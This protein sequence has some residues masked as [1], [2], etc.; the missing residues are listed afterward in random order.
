MIKKRYGHYFDYLI[1]IIKHSRHPKLC[2]YC[3]KINCHELIFLL[4]LADSAVSSLKMQ[5][6][7][8]SI[9]CGLVP[10]PPL[11]LLGEQLADTQSGD[12][13]ETEWEY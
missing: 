7:D 5:D 10:L 9:T 13:E 11:L 4:S 8:Q 2:F 1:M 6:A 12:I 3:L